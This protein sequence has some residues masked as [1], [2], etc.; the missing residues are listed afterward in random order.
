MDLK[1]YYINTKDENNVKFSNKSKNINITDNGNT[2][3]SLTK[4]K[5][6]KEEVALM[7]KIA[8]AKKWNLAEI[9]I[10][11]TKDFVKEAQKQIAEKLRDNKK[12]LISNQKEEDTK[13]RA[14]SEVQYYKKEIIDEKFK[15]DINTKV[16]LQ[17]I[18]E[19]LKAEIILNYARDYYKIDIS[20]F[21]I[22]K[23]N[24]INDKT[25]KQKP[26]NIIDFIQVQAKLTSKEA[27]DIVENL[28]EN[29]GKANIQEAVKKHEK[30]K[31]VQKENNKKIDENLDIIVKEKVRKNRERER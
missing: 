24:K 31:E 2:I 19:D 8:E 9:E 4:S 16:S 5:S 25:N 28:Y 11:G 13:T 18:K 10:D 1:G 21:E 29:I 12:D 17:K 26:K 3:Q 27:I 20:K 15:E 30:I 6:L 7:I 14:N 22:T 23:D